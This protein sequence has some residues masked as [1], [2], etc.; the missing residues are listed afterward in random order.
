VPLSHQ[1]RTFA[2]QSSL[3]NGAAIIPLTSLAAAAGAF[4]VENVLIASPF[5]LLA[6]AYGLIELSRRFGG[7]APRGYLGVMQTFW[8]EPPAAEEGASA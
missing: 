8:E 3:K 4:G 2:L 6:L 7:H 1:G 5:V